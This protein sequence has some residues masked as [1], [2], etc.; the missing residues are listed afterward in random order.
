MQKVQKPLGRYDIETHFDTCIAGLGTVGFF[1]GYKQDGKVLL[2]TKAFGNQ[3]EFEANLS[4]T[5]VARM[6]SGAP[7]T[8]ILNIYL[9]VPD[10]E[11][12]TNSI[13]LDIGPVADHPN[14]EA[15]ERYMRLL[16]QTVIEGATAQ[17]Q[18][19]SVTKRL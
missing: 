12:N 5:D 10:Y 8:T 15:C 13:R 19:V 1:F 18:T 6:R 2:P 14:W 11:S 9:A 16:D 4:M 17:S 7:D 3:D